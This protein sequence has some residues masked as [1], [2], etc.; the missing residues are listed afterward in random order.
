[1]IIISDTLRTH[2]NC[3]LSVYPHLESLGRCRD[4]I[5]RNKTFG[6]HLM[7]M[8]KP[9]ESTYAT[10]ELIRNPDFLYLLAQRQGSTQ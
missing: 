5:H 1:M 3:D 8:Y 2:S 7:C 10:S 9:V 6:V 4:D